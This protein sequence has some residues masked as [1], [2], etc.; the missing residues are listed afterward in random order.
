VPVVRWSAVLG[1]VIGRRRAFATV[2]PVSADVV[3]A[4][5]A[6][7]AA[8]RELVV[9]P[10]PAAAGPVLVRFPGAPS[11][12]MGFEG[13]LD[14][15][16]DGAR[17][18]GDIGR[19]PFGR[20]H[21]TMFVL[22]AVLLLVIGAVGLATDGSIVALVAGLVA[23]GLVAVTV[24][25]DRRSVARLEVALAAALAPGGASGPPTDWRAAPRGR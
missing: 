5:L 11:Y 21:R 13:R 2:G 20:V 4:R 22:V 17:L 3:A 23:V 6:R 15:V 14:S 18:Q 1:S 24:R 9:A 8:A 7:R 25:V 10:S 16:D 19:P 12:A